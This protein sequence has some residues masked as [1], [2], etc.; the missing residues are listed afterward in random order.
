MHDTTTR[1]RALG[2][3]HDLWSM[4]VKDLARQGNKLPETLKSELISLGLWSMRYSTVAILNDL[5]LAPLIEVNRNVAAGIAGQTSNIPAHHSETT[6][7]AAP[8]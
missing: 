8:V 1:I 6:L 5:P 7:S 3:N 4:L 2:R